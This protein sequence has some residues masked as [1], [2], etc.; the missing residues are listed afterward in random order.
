MAFTK[1]SE[2]IYGLGKIQLGKKDGVVYA[3]RITMLDGKNKGQIFDVQ[4]FPDGQLAGKFNVYLTE[5]GKELKRAIPTDE[6]L[7]VKFSD[8]AHKE[9]EKPTPQTNL[10][11]DYEWFTVILE[12]TGGEYEGLILPVKLQYW[13]ADSYDPKTN[14]T[15]CGIADKNTMWRDKLTNFGKFEH[16][17]TASGADRYTL[18]YQPNMLPTLQK[19]LKQEGLEFR[20][21][22]GPTGFVEDFL[23]AESET[24]VWDDNLDDAS[25]EIVD[26]PT[27]E[28]SEDAPLKP[29]VEIKDGIEE[30][31]AELESGAIVNFDDD[32]IWEEE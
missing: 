23:P 15:I 27:I 2:N 25:E 3:V 5:R 24:Q 26:E 29:D 31:E 11:Y 16:F 10:E 13:F 21:V 12:V 7:P 22:T 4:K 28:F 9:N 8:I 19:L 32:G 6:I 20:V 14:T 17:L 18:K 1:V 30:F